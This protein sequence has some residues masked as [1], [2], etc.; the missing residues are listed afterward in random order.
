MFL[1]IFLILPV[2][3]CLNIVITVVV[4]L[5]SLYCGYNCHFLNH[6]F[7]MKGDAVRQVAM[8]SM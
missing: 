2:H 5:N 1:S 7:K 8:S 4:G 3:A 6:G